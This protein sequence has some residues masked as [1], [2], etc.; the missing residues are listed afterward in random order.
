MAFSKVSLNG[1]GPLRVQPQVGEWGPQQVV[2]ARTKLRQRALMPLL[3]TAVLSALAGVG[4]FMFVQLSTGP[5]SRPAEIIVAI[6]TWLIPIVLVLSFV[7][8]VIVWIAAR[9]YRDDGQ[10]RTEEDLGST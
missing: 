2:T 9:P 3:L 7:L 5:M 4:A 8:A 10:T 1:D 6:G